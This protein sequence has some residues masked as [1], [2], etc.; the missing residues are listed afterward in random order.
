M[1]LYVISCKKLN[2]RQ[3]FVQGTHAAIEWARVN[4]HHPALVM[5]ECADIEK[6]HQELLDKGFDLFTFNDS[7]YNYR[8]TAIASTEIGEAVKDLKLI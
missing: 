1:K 3:R 8:L 2:K 4:N 6:L 5:L 7:Y